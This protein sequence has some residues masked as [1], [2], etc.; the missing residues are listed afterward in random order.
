LLR[1]SRGNS[2]TALTISGAAR[3]TAHGSAAVV[4]V[5]TTTGGGAGATEGGAVCAIAEGTV[6]SGVLDT[7]ESLDPHPAAVIVAAAMRMAH[8]TTGHRTANATRR[9]T[10]ARRGNALPTTRLHPK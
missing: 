8:F 6:G 5:G 2:E 4:V 1:G 10:G 9:Q 7:V 3:L